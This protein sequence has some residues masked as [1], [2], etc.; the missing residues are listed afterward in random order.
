M[1]DPYTRV[2]LHQ[3]L[4]MLGSHVRS[5]QSLLARAII[6][7]PAYLNSV[8]CTIDT[9]VVWNVDVI[10]KQLETGFDAKWGRNLA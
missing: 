9:W 10:E 1:P 4:A 7:D 3:D 5:L 6:E 8:V 2:A